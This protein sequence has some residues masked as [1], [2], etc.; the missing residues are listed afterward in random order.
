M[1]VLLKLLSIFTHN[2]CHPNGRVISIGALV[3]WLVLRWLQP[4]LCKA[5]RNTRSQHKPFIIENHLQLLVI[6]CGAFVVYGDLTTLNVSIVVAVFFR[7][8]PYEPAECDDGDVMSHGE[9]GGLWG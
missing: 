2:T 4:L 9:P 6:C 5:F 7:E 1:H 3:L 8:T